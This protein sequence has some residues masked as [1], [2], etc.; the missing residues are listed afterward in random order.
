VIDKLS[1]KN[2]RSH[3]DTVL[4]LHPG[5][6]V[7]VGLPNKGKTNILRAIKWLV[8]NRPLG[9]RVRARGVSK[10]TCVGMEM[11]DVEISLVLGKKG[12]RY[13][14][15]KKGED[16]K[17]Y[18]AVG[19]SVPDI[20][21]K[22]LN[23]SEVNVQRQLD[24]PYLITE[25]GS[26]VSKQLN[27]IT[28]L[29]KVDVWIK[30]LNSRILS[31]GKTV[32]LLEGQVREK[33]ER[34][35]K[36][37]GVK[38]L[39]R[40]LDALLKLERRK[41]LLDVRASRLSNLIAE[42]EQADRAEKLYKRLPDL[43][44]RCESA[45]ASRNVIRVLDGQIEELKSFARLIKDSVSTVNQLDREIMDGIQE[46]KGELLRHKRCPFCP[47][48]TTDIGKHNVEQLLEGV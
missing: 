30:K 35:V 31:K 15:K 2:F 13:E 19:S 46:Y 6:N 36:L 17:K 3:P 24:G 47:V 14:I 23:L 44:E 28:R 32:S 18:K 10:A 5:V 9:A 43:L 48:C 11:G 45:I 1:L 16:A 33:K 29:E 38:Q 8:D 39:K 41:E 20:V 12:K 25:S 42:I 37:K 21:T 26:E 27:R 4:E 22:A 7:I 34:V 40:E